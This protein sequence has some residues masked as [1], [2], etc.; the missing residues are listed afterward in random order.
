M[1][2]IGIVYILKH[3]TGN[4][5][6]VGETRVSSAKRLAAYMKE[7]SLVNFEPFNKDTQ[8]NEEPNTEKEDQI[9]KEQQEQEQRKKLLF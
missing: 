8:K 4:L 3:S 2:D 6:K 7:H 9:K 1:A 5:V